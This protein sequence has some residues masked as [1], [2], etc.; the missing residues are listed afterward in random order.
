[1]NL[2]SHALVVAD[3][4][5]TGATVV[6]QQKVLQ[7]RTAEKCLVGLPASRKMNTREPAIYC[8]RQDRDM[9]LCDV[10]IEFA[11]PADAT[12][13]P[14][15]NNWQAQLESEAGVNT[16]LNRSRINQ[17]QIHRGFERRRWSVWAE[18]RVEAN[19]NTECR[20]GTEQEIW[21][22]RKPA[23]SRRH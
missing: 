23:T 3:R 4:H 10:H 15:I 14:P 22:T 7:E 17:G 12:H 11:R 21:T 8:E 16:A 1:M 5:F 2:S 19:L 9:D 6:T 13:Q 20:S 18:G